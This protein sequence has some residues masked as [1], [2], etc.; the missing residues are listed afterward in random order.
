M[1]VI[2]E[3]NLLSE[4]KE[5]A[6]LRKRCD[7]LKKIQFPFNIQEKSTP[8]NSF[9]S[10][11]QKKINELDSGTKNL[12]RELL[13]SI[14]CLLNVNIYP[15]RCPYCDTQIIKK[16]EIHFLLYRNNQAF[17][18]MSY[19]VS[20]CKN[21]N[22][23][24]ISQSELNSIKEIAS[25]RHKS[26]PS[27]INIFN[28]PSKKGLIKDTLKEI[29]YPENDKKRTYS[30]LSL[31][32]LDPGIESKLPYNKSTWGNSLPNLTHVTAS[33]ELLIYTKKCSCRK[34][35][36]KYKIPT[37]LS[38][39]AEVY[40]IDGSLCKV[41]VQFCMGC[42]QYFMDSRSLISYSRLYKKF[43]FK[44]IISDDAKSNEPKVG[45]Y[46]AESSILSR[47]GYN[48]KA[49]T[50]RTYRQDILA[51]LMMYHI[52]EKHE[53]IELL[54]QFIWFHEKTHPAACDRWM[55]DIEFVNNFNIDNQEY[56]GLLKMR[57]GGK[58]SRIR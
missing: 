14:P 22:I 17:T 41:N 38:R 8:A 56:A 10:T 6:N 18:G 48:V 39:T 43:D 34:C 11:T 52:T 4:K 55:E 42:G 32:K 9:I 36:E 15:Y 35:E 27:V 23:P 37:T 29:R 47:N 54:N 28:Y 58:L 7:V 30:P 31:S 57:Q 19:N 16:Q 45:G 20:Y 49:K 44:Y 40:S 53:I 24:V 3:S 2:D 50:S 51:C 33:K 5:C 1:Q 12:S 21:C 26:T 13:Y 25:K 46:F